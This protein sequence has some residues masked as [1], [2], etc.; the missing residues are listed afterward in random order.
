M[1]S[2]DLISRHCT[3]VFHRFDLQAYCFGWCV[4][5]LQMQSWCFD[6][7]QQL[8]G[9]EGTAG[10]NAKPPGQTCSSNCPRLGGG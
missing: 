9:A 2:I 3:I 8:L 7:R 6:L 4:F 1:C 10:T 5:D